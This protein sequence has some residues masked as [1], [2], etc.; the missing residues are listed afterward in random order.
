MKMKAAI[1]YGPGDIR[2][3]EIEKPEANPEGAVVK[4]KACGVCNIMDAIYWEQWQPGGAGV[5][6]VRGHEWSGEIAE[7]GSKVQDFKVGDRVYQNPVFRPCYNCTYCRVG[8]YWKCINWG[9]GISDRAINGAMA[10]YLWIPFITKESAVK[11]PDDISFRDLAM[12]EPLYLSVG[13]AKKARPEDVVLVLGQDLI[14]LGTVVML[15]EYGVAKVITADIS[16]LRLKASKDIGADVVIDSLNED[17]AQV[18]MKETA[19]VGA[20][21]IIVNDQ[22][23][24]ALSHAVDSVRRG[25]TVWQATYYSVPF[26][27]SN[28]ITGRGTNWIGP[29]AGYTQANIIY[30]PLLLSMQT[31][32]GSLGPR[33][34]RWEE[35]VKVLLQPKKMTADKLVTHVFP[36]EKTKEAFE[37]AMNPHETIKVMVEP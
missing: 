36:L 26:I 18:V 27:E 16:Q 6:F 31:A 2:I 35:S 23:P 14:G 34:P 22:R 10:E 17:V 29:G 5:G 37:M 24:I 15:K 25:G 3:K 1:Y 8:D 33:V 19:G 4:V 9:K 32:W 20:D 21:V 28:Q 13:L 11:L 7:V 30:D 12:I